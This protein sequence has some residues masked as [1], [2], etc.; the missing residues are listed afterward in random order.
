MS[1]FLHATTNDDGIY[2]FLWSISAPLLMCTTFLSALR[3]TLSA[4]HRVEKSSP[5]VQSFRE[6]GGGGVLK[7]HNPITLLTISGVGL[8]EV[9]SALTDKLKFCFW[10]LSR[11]AS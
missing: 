8:S 9:L 5:N 2:C 10:T 7:S 1:S 4:L 3:F 6:L 11:G